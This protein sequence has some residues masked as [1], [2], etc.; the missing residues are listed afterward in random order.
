MI[1]ITIFSSHRAERGLLQPLI[2]RLE[3]HPTFDLVIFS[4]HPPADF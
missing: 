1:R 2:N 3:A 4:L